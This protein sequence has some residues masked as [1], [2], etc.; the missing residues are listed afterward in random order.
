M[1]N[2]AWSLWLTPIAMFSPFVI[3]P[4]LMDFGSTMETL[5]EWWDLYLFLFGIPFLLG[6]IAWT[7]ARR[8][9][10]AD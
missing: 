9:E 10:R 1:R 5:A 6:A 3:L 2:L 4:F 7:Y 8:L